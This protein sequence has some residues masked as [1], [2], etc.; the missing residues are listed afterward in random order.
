[1]NTN[2]SAKV[3]LCYGDS[4]TWGDIPNADGRHAPNVRWV[5]VLQDTLGNGY[6]VIGEG[7][8]GRTFEAKENGKEHRVG[9]THLRSILQTNCPIDFITVMLGTNDL[10]SIFGLKVEEIAA[11]L[12]KTLEFI[13][14]EDMEINEKPPKILVICPPLSSNLTVRSLTHA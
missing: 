5:G 7:L 4:N 1:M 8:N 9:I 10:K 6:E 11:H 12:R 14:N 13:Q 2:P 3:V